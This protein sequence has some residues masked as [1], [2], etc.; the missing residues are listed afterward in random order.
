[1]STIKPRPE[2]LTTREAAEYLTLREHTLA[3]WRSSGRHAL[4]FVKIGGAV[5]YKRADLDDFIA[6]RTV[7]ASAKKAATSAAGGE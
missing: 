1:M 7:G 5:R 4:P 6:A 3:I 2:L